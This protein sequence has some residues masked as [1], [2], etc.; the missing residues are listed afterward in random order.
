MGAIAFGMGG[1]GYWYEKSSIEVSGELILTQGQLESAVCEGRR[2][3]TT[4]Q[5]G[6]SQ[7]IFLPKVEYSYLY[8]GVIYQSQRYGRVRDL[9]IGSKENCDK[10]IAKSL[11]K[12]NIEVWVDPSQPN[13]A[14]LEPN[15]NSPFLEYIFMGLGILLLLDGTRHQFKRKNL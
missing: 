12:K 13:L 15:L 7:I 9:E 1:Y 2:W 3:H 4:T 10:Y 11:S 14:V 5:G 8:K 6:S